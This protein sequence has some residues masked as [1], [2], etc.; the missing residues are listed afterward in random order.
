MLA[1]IEE[2]SK[3]LKKEKNEVSED[4]DEEMAAD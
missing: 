3:I 4:V 2:Y 1:T